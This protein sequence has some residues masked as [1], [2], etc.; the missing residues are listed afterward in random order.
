MPFV[1]EG[2]EVL[3]TA[4]IGIALSSSDYDQGSDLLQNADIAMFRAKTKGK[5]CYEVFDRVMYVQ[6]LEQ[7]QLENDLRQA[8]VER[9]FQVYYQPIV[10]LNTGRLTGFEALVRWQHPVRGLVSPVEFI[11]M[12]EETGLIVPIG[13][14]VLRE[15]AQQMSVWQTKFSTQ[16]PLKIS[17]NLSVRQLKEPDFLEKI[18]SILVQTGLAGQSLQLELTESMLMD[19]VKQLIGIL[20]HLRARA[21]QL[22]IDDFGTGYSSLSYLHRFPVNNLKIDRSFVSRIGEQ[23]ENQELVET[24]VTLAHQLGMEAIAEGVETLQQLNQLQALNC[25]EAQGYLFSKPLE[26]ES[27]EALIS[28]YVQTNTIDGVATY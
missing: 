23:G 15:A 10:S 16:A 24:I 5:A 20:N 9:Q 17:V 7:L 19:N 18:D 28:R 14:W 3:A 1:L 6:A 26:R 22:S 21:I 4:S 13:E 27:A 25:E 8:L 11:P 2:R 12:A